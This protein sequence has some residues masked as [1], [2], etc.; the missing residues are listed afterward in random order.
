MGSFA[1]V[2]LGLACAHLKIPLF[3]HEGNVWAGKANRFLA[4]YANKFLASFPL[5]NGQG[6]NSPIVVTGMP[7]YQT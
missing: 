5:A 6:I 7:S 3:V 4:K 1:G 2:P